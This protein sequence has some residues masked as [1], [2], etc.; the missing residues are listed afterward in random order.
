[1]FRFTWFLKLVVVVLLGTAI[2]GSVALAAKIPSQLKSVVTFIFVPIV[3]K[4]QKQVLAKIGTG[5]FVGVSLP[6]KPDRMSVYLVTSKHIVF[7]K[8]LNKCRSVIVVRLNKK[9]GGFVNANLRLRK[10]GEKKNVFFHK[11]STVDVAVIPAVPNSTVVDYKA[12]EVKQLATKADIAKFKIGEGTDVF[13]TGLFTPYIG[14]HKNYPIVRFGKVAL[15][16][17]EKIMFGGEPMDLYLVEVTSFGGNSGSPVYFFLGADRNPGALM[18]GP[19]IIKLAGVMQ[20]NW[21]K[22]KQIV[23]VA[24]GETPASL[25]N[26][27]I[28]AVVPAY[29]LLEILYGEELKAA[30]GW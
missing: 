3:D 13:F 16:S 17:D 9:G 20:G 28:S 1:M 18:L 2:L 22:K 26:M 5:F 6:H 7:N 29:K 15:L 11:D 4:D 19:S 14:T 24:E 30:R 12:L 27:G 21:N 25:D 23:Y 10:T 8:K